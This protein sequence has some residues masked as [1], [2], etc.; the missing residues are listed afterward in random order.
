MAIAPVEI[1][2]STV[3]VEVSATHLPPATV[4]PTGRRPD[5]QEVT[6]IRSA[7][8]AYNALKDLLSGLST[9]VKQQA[10]ELRPD[11]CTVEAKIGF[12]GEVNPV[13]FLVAAKS[14]ASL[15]LTLTWKANSVGVAPTSAL[16]MQQLDSR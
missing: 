4:P 1:A 9:L 8:D 11:E 2:G 12:A 10:Q 6:A 14:D 3:L 16:L 15:T 5:T 7:A 13:P